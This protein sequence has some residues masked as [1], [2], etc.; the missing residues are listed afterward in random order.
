MRAHTPGIW[1]A[2]YHKRYKVWNVFADGTGEAIHTSSISDRDD[3]EVEANANLIA[4]A[5]DLL[6]ALH[7]CYEH[8]RLYH[9]AVETNNVG[10]AV[11]AAIAKA[12]G[13]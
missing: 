3:A 13:A 10:E 4:A 12:E 7:L 1:A 8:C 2:E 5:P 6:E 11:R 9:R